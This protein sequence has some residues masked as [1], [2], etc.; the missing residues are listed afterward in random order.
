MEHL[1][2][3]KIALTSIFAALYYMMSYLPGVPAIGLPQVK[4]QIE[5]C[6]ASVFGM[7]LGP[8][9][10]AL[11]TFIGVYA[12]WALPP[13]SASLTGLI[14]LPSPVI[15]AFT[16]GLI[17][18]GG[19]RKAFVILA[20]L[21]AVFWIL[22]PVQPIEQNFIVGIVA[23]WDK[24]LALL[25]I[26]PAFSLLKRIIFRKFEV[27]SE[28]EDFGRETRKYSLAIIL[29]LL[30]AILILVNAFMIAVNGDILRFSFE[31]QNETYKI[32]FGSKF[33]VK[34][35]ASYGYVWLALGV[36]ILA[37]VIIFHIKPEY[38]IFCGGAVIALSGF[39]AIIGGGFIVGLIL[40]VMGGFLIAIKKAQIFRASSMESLTYFLLAFIGNE[41]DNAWGNTIFAVPAVYEGIFQ[42]PLEMVRWSFLFSPY[43]YSIIRTIQA[44]IA[45]LIAVPLV[46]NLRSTRFGL[47]SM[48]IKR[49]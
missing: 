9:L 17:C 41:A 16:V 27:G 12:S 35:M 42:M 24:I 4:I 6:M 14:F 20:L 45:A 31:F 5:A 44:I 15:N 11:A 36:G 30:S 1:D 2:S 10:G 47:P 40:G 49:D 29:S 26:P 22:P 32:S 8:Y 28:N 48:L 7:I 37:S 39:S 38:S 34:P 18:K 33:F 23:M 25:L 19:W 46:N 13:G 21:I 43:A 3:K